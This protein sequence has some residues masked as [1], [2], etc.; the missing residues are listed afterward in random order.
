MNS[1]SRILPTLLFALAF[2]EAAPGCNGEVLSVGADEAGVTSGDGGLLTPDGGDGGRPVADGGAPDGS[3][4]RACYAST[5]CNAGE[6]CG[7]AIDGACGEAGKCFPAFSG[8]PCGAFAA[9]CGCDGVTE[10]K[11]VCNGFPSGYA[12]APVASKT[13]CGAAIDAGPAPCSATADCPSGQLC[14]FLKA[15]AC[16][17]T[18]TCMSPSEPPCNAF[19]AACACDG[20]VI[21]D[22]CTGLPSSYS[23]A[24][25]D[26]TGACLGIDA[27]APADV[28]TP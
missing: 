4:D 7:F 27:G 9:G 26:A 20:S 22:I 15:S 11:I 17:A 19:K 24:P 12:S 18:G 28:G 16:T 14:G 23:T 2:V 10:V 8:G 21:N 13:A 1:V 5:D 3:P 6:M 25:Y